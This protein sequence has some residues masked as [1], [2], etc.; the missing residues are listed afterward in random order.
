MAHLNIEFKARCDDL[1]RVRALLVAEGARYVGED[2]QID[3]YFPVPRGRLKLRQGT[4]EQALIYYERPD[5]LGPKASDVHLAPVAD[6][7]AVRVLLAAALGI[8][9]VVDKRRAIYFA[10]NVKIH[11]DCVDGLGTF[12]EVEAIDQL[13]DRDRARLEA[14]C[15]HYL[16]RFAIAEADLVDASYSDLLERQRTKEEGQ[17]PDPSAKPT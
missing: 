13:G 14:Q 7:E 15:R 1:G 9:V 3:T 17:R 8:R 6:G 16:K 4:I 11:L 12:V 2:R 5:Q 10:G